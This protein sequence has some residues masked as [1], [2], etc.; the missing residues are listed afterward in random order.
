MTFKD[1]AK[2]LAFLANMGIK[3]TM[4]AT[5]MRNIS[6]RM[7]QKDIQLKYREPGVEVIDKDT[8]AFGATPRRQLRQVPRPVR[9]AVNGTNRIQNL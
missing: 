9:R 1:S 6:M 4:A 3:G 2:A 7:S 8:G 5:A